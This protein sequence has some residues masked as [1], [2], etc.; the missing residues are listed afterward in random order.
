MVVVEQRGAGLAWC[1][2]GSGPTLVFLHGLGGTRT[3]WADQMS[4]LSRNH[5]CVA[6]DMPGYGDS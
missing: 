2:T 4:A 6:W 3:A 5:R 1:E